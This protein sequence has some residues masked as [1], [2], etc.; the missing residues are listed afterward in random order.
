MIEILKESYVK[1]LSYEL[2]RFLMVGGTTV[3]IDLISYVVLVYAGFDTSISKGISFSIGTVFAYFVNRKFT[4]RSHIA[5][6]YS[7]IIFIL[8]YLSTLGVNVVINEIILDYTSRTGLYFTI[9]FLLS[10]LSSA[11]LN[12]IG[13]KYIVF[14]VGKERIV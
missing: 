3:I 13:M 10:T 12:F 6:P 9:A 8:L 5:G 11:T 14:S 7:F 1:L 4:F 2:G